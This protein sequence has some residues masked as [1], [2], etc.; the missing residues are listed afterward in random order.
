MKQ[1]RKNHLHENELK[2]N[3]KNKI[4]REKKKHLNIFFNNLPIPTLI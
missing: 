1:G 4:R 3:L 2:L